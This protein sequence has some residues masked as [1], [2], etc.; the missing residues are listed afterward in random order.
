MIQYIYILRYLLLLWLAALLCLPLP[1]MVYAAPQNKIAAPADH[2]PAKADESDIQYY[3]CS[4]HPQIHLPQPGKCPICGMDLIPV[5]K[6]T[7]QAN[8]E[9]QSLRRLKLSPY[10]EKLAEVQTEPVE[11]K[12][13]QADIRMVGTVDYDETRLA[14]ITAWVPGR[15]DK[16]YVDF[17][18]TVVKKGDPM[19]YLYSPQLLS[20]QQE[21]L[22]S[23]RAVGQLQ[24][25]RLSTILDT[26]QA[27]VAA[28][29]EK[30]R[31]LG[32]TSQQIEDVI[33]RGKPS[34]HTTIMA[35]LTGVVIR[36]NGVEGMYVQTGTQIYAIADLSLVWIKLDAY[37]S[38]LAYIRTGQEVQFEAEAYPGEIF[39]GTVDFID[40][41]LKDKTRTVKVRL[42]A[43][44]P[45]GKLKPEMF[46]HAVLRAT[47]DQ[48]CQVVT[49]STKVE[50]PPLV[51]PASAP[52]ITGKRA[53]VYVAVPEQPG[54]YVGREIVLGPRAG[55]Y[56]LVRAGLQEGDQV[57][58]HGNF[59]ID[60][61]LQIRAEPSMMTPEGGGGMMAHQ[62]SGAPAATGKGGPPAGMEAPETFK[63]Q[64]ALVFTAQ[65]EL[66]AAME[67]RDLNTIRQKFANVHRALLRVD[68]TLLSG[69]PRM[70][71]MELDMLLEN[72]AV[73]GSEADTLRD[74]RRNL[75][76]LT[77]HLDRVRGQFMMAR[78]TP[79]VGLPNVKSEQMP[80]AFQSQI[81]RL[82]DAYFAVQK[83]LAG[84]QLNE[85]QQGIRSLKQEAAAIDV[86]HL[87]SDTQKTWTQLFPRFEAGLG[88]L[89]QAQDLA[90]L[91]KTFA[92]VS[93]ALALIVATFGINPEHPVYQLHCPM[94]F[95][96][97]GAT[98]LQKTEEV[99]NPYFG[100]SMLGCGDLVR[101]LFAGAKK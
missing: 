76:E 89:S 55:D 16:L 4:M 98:W 36:K 78:G 26:A 50:K 96:G 22:Q 46:V 74:A 85:A 40:P 91:R 37:E 63:R 62:H 14:Y 61:A 35:P 18:G 71:W 3:T 27:T 8:G 44:N 32:L 93:D 6:E 24:Q 99:R 56:Y 7:H 42:N 86:S 20:A 47:L 25:S 100:Q 34:D 84:D 54:T 75:D 41:F 33:R 79:A 101:T 29:K 94:A 48:D 73:I 67:T 28:S 81:G 39:K 60:S 38:D 43:S 83:A 12:F 23:L 92:P 10:A 58:T 19:V 51:I 1:A 30:L 97:Q 57:V 45:K 69:H 66:S 17:T 2:L 53:V 9:L 49:E 21:L 72:D 13:V 95:E 88:E 87:K 5:K 80:K 68:P 15:I 90:T 65:D 59:K 77:K 70:V 11:R 82:L 52:L 64:L 31:L